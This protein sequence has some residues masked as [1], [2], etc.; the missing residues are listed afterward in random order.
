MKIYSRDRELI[1]DTPF[2]QDSYDSYLFQAEIEKNE[3]PA[4]LKIERVFL[5]ARADF[6]TGKLSLD[7]FSDICQALYGIISPRYYDDPL[8]LFDALHAGAELNFYVRQNNVRSQKSF[9]DFI[10]EVL[11]YKK[12]W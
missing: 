2:P 10:L 4:N 5:L 3:D 9:M 11:N 12:R 6:L 8:P 1:I 7:G